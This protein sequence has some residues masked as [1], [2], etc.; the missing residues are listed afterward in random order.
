MSKTL[1]N[2]PPPVLAI[3]AVGAVWWLSQRRAQAA[4]MAGRPMP[5]PTYGTEAAVAAGRPSLISPSG[6]VPQA[7][8]SP[9]SAFLSFAQGLIGRGPQPTPAIRPPSAEDYRFGGPSVGVYGEPMTPGQVPRPAAYVPTWTP[10]T[11]GEAAASEY[12]LAHM[13]EFAS[14]PSPVYWQEPVPTTGGWIDQQ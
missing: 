11:A 12:Y 4:P 9:V 14:Q 6:V 13:D 3:L 8:T 1:S 5:T 7:A 10:D 2:L